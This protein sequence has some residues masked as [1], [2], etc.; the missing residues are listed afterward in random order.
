MN[1]NNHSSVTGYVAGDG[2]FFPA[3]GGETG[4]QAVLYFSIGVTR[5]PSR[6]ETSATD[7]IDCAIYGTRAEAL[8]GL[9]TKG[10]HV[11]VLGALRT[12]KDSGLLNASD[13]SQTSRVTTQVAVEDV[14]FLQPAPKS[15]HTEAPVAEE[16]T[17][18][19]ALEEI[20][21]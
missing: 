19:P 13:Q 17:E 6:R 18:A 8:N 12:R 21:L 2:R 10:K 15:Q 14:S 5:M 9:I 20:A 4:K 11:Q 3:T 16:P 1:S 7:W